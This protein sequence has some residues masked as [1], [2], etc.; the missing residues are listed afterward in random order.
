MH[1]SFIYNIIYVLTNTY[2]T[3]FQKDYCVYYMLF[4]IFT[5]DTVSYSLSVYYFPFAEKKRGDTGSY[6]LSVFYIP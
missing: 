1:L 3:V 2:R 5:G 6:S 4:G